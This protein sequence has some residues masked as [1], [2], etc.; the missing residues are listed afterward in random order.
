MNGKLKGDIE[1]RRGATQEEVLELA[2]SSEKLRRHIEGGTLRRVI[3][4]QDR[5]L[6]LVITK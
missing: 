5:L 6:N 4:V 3:H 1:A 2:R